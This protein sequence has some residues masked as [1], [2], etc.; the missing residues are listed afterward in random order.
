VGKRKREDYHGMILF[1]DSFLPVDGSW[2]TAVQARL[3][4][5]KQSNQQPEEREEAN[6]RTPG[7]QTRD[8]Y[9]LS[10]IELR[11]LD[12]IQGSCAA[13]GFL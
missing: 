2:E 8:Y 4:I 11:D 3:I 6:S 13:G 12:P 7:C 9:L 1:S 5:C 10:R